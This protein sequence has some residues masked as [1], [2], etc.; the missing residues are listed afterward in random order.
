MTTLNVKVL[1]GYVNAQAPLQPSLQPHRPNEKQ[2]Q[3]VIS[4]KPRVAHLKQRHQGQQ[5]TGQN[6][7]L[8]SLFDGKSH[9]QSFQPD[10]TILLHGDPADAIYRVVSGTVRC[11]T[12]SAE[13]DRQIFRFI[14]KGEC[15]GL[16]DMD[17][18]HFTAEAVDHVIL[19]SIPR[20][21]VEQ[22]LAVSVS[23]RQ[24]LR[25]D[26]CNQLET[27]E[28]QL[29]SMVASKAPE[30][31]FNFLQEFASQRSG[32]G[33]VA[34]PMCRRDIADHLG[35][36]VE[37]VSRA[38]S[39]LKNNGRIALVTAEKFKILGNAQ[40]TEVEATAIRPHMPCDV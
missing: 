11:C 20:A 31:L 21:I 10:S 5:P 27:R 7:T 35:M 3:E 34:L 16:A 26:M 9:Q 17:T 15:F 30:R 13:G 2:D 25:A 38:F 4:F 32:N 1:P 14:H 29:L 40:A 24:D 28:R 19:K 18:W 33:Y 8:A 12:I 22:I 37:T 23:V 36:T 39:D 6:D